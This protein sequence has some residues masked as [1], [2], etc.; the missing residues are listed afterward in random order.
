MPTMG[1]DASLRIEDITA[2]VLIGTFIPVGKKLGNKHSSPYM[3]GGKRT[4]KQNDSG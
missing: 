1:S 4:I 3:S 2:I